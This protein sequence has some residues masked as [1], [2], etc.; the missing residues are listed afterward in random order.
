MIT[1]NKLRALSESAD[2][3]DSDFI[4]G[5][6]F[7][8]LQDFDESAFTF[9][10]FDSEDSINESIGSEIWKKIKAAFHAIRKFFVMIGT[11]IK[12]FVIGFFKKNDEELDKFVDDNLDDSLER[13]KKTED[14]VEEIKRESA[15]SLR[16]HRADMAK[17]RQTLEDFKKRYNDITAQSKG[18]GE[19]IEKAQDEIKRYLPRWM[20]R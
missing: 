10:D 14:L 11:K 7:D 16:K 4:P 5:I 1:L 19:N 17:H 15:E 9:N 2:Y 18:V 20:L 3:H 8:D 6:G 13:V 12:N